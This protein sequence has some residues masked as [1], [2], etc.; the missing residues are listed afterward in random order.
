MSSFSRFANGR[1]FLS[2]RPGTFAV[3]HPDAVKGHWGQ[4]CARRAET[5]PAETVP[6]YRRM[7]TETL[8]TTGR[9]SYLAAARLLVRLGAVC[10]ATGTTAEFVEFMATTVETNRRR[11][12]C[13]DELVRAGL[14][15]RDRSVV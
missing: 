2:R 4:L 10:T 3:E 12:T 5:A 8:A 9:S 13:I 14:I 7:V 1:S 11:P 15:R 6:H